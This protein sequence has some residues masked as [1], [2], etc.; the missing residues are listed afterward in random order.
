[1][2][3]NVVFMKDILTFSDTANHDID[4]NKSV[5]WHKCLKIQVP[6]NS[7]RTRFNEI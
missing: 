6:L 3:K 2:F 5:S 7:V 4:K 1:M